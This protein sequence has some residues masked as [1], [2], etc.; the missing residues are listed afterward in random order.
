MSS[1][2]YSMSLSSS[3]TSDSENLLTLSDSENPSPVA[4]QAKIL[5]RTHTSPHFSIK[6]RFKK[7][8]SI[9]TSAIH[10]HHRVTQAFSDFAKKLLR[11]HGHDAIPDPIPPRPDKKSLENAKVG[12]LLQVR[13]ADVV[14]DPSLTER[15]DLLILVKSGDTRYLKEQSW[16]AFQS[17]ADTAGVSDPHQEVLLH[18]VN[19]TIVVKEAVLASQKMLEAKLQFKLTKRDM[20]AGMEILKGDIAKL[21]VKITKGEGTPQDALQIKNFEA[22]LHILEEQ[23]RTLP[24]VDD[25]LLVD[26]GGNNITADRLNVVNSPHVFVDLVED[27]HRIKIEYACFLEVQGSRKQFEFRKEF[28]LNRD[29]RSVYAV[30]VQYFL[31]NAWGGEVRES[32]NL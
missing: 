22:R 10:Q 5:K 25:V 12:T 1:S 29:V 19:E 20:K 23:N 8:R 28:W 16:S 27:S 18:L 14:V 6:E 24:I 31:N 9:S 26:E 30:D 21:H 32:S 13:V 15:L 4:E 2:S 17:S 7:K 3:Y 11:K